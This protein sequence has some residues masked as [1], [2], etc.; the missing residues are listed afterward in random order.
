MPF[1]G[2]VVSGLEEEK[3]PPLKTLPKEQCPP[4]VSDF[5]VQGE[6]ED[7]IQRGIYGEAFILIT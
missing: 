6:D 3:W 2:L 5:I 7:T 4:E 1:L